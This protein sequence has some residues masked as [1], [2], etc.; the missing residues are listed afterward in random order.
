MVRILAA[1]LGVLALGVITA[2]VNALDPVWPVFV[3]S[4]ALLALASV[5]ATHFVPESHKAVSEL[6]IAARDLPAFQRE[7][8]TSQL[9][10]FATK[11]GSDH[12]WSRLLTGILVAVSGLIVTTLAKG[13]PDAEKLVRLVVAGEALAVALYTPIAVRTFHMLRA[14]TA[15]RREITNRV[16]E[17]ARRRAE[18]QGLAKIMVGS[19]ESTEALNA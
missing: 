17:V 5:F 1:V 2:V 18:L 13:G 16:G 12:I 9:D 6:L 19:R 15:L 10:R 3:Y 11:S 7:P 8:I 14:S 4:A